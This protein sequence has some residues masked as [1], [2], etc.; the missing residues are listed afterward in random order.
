MKRARKCEPSVKSEL[1]GLCRFFMLSMPL[2]IG[3]GGAKPVGCRIGGKITVAA[4]AK[5]PSR[6]ACPVIVVAV[7]AAR[8]ASSPADA[9][10]LASLAKHVV[11]V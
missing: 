2:Q 9:T 3:N 4:K 10:E 1:I 5:K 8:A 11:L 7:Q 6:L